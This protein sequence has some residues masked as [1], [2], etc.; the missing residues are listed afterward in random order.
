MRNH[1]KAFVSVGG[2]WYI[3]ESKQVKNFL[4]VS[5]NRSSRSLFPTSYKEALEADPTHGYASIY[6][7]IYLFYFYFLF[8]SDT[9]GTQDKLFTAS[10]S[11]KGGDD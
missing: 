9:E 3:V 4:G 11:A 5:E 10:K 6:V 8:F 1:G 2:Y 7:C